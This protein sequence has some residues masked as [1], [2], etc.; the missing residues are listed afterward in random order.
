MTN[1]G[2][3]LGSMAFLYIVDLDMVVKF[4]DHSYSI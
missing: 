4:V 2:C 1:A 3:T